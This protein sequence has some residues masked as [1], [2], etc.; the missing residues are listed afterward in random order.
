MNRNKKKIQIISLD[1]PNGY[2]EYLEKLLFKNGI[3]RE[4][5]AIYKKVKKSL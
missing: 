5:N 1:I 2:L 3:F 4:N